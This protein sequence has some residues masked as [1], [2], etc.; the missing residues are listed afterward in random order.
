MNVSIGTPLSNTA[1]KSYVALALGQNIEEARAKV[2]T[3]A[4]T[5][6]FDL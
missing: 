1:K 4:D 3:A 6:E 2:N 5:V